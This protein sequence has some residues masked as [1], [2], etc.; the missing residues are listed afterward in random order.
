[1][2]REGVFFDVEPQAAIEVAE[3]CLAEVVALCDDD[4]VLVLK[5]RQGGERRAEHRVG[6]DERMTARSVKL[7]QA[8]FHRG[9]VGDN[10]PFGYVGH[11]GVES[12]EGVFDGCGVDYEFGT[13]VVDLVERGKSQCVE[14][15]AQALRVGV[16][17][18]HFVGEGE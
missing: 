13:E 14:A 3:E 18:G 7:G 6:R 15:E 2:L 10:A 8:V 11:D 5:V 16:V 9:D 1:M 4:C 17:D 12:V